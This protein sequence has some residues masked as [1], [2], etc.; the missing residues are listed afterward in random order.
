MV[1][2]A[3]KDTDI[4]LDILDYILIDQLIHLGTSGFGLAIEDERIN[5]FLTKLINELNS[6]KA[7][8]KE[9]NNA[10]ATLNNISRLVEIEEDF[11]YL[12]P[13]KLIGKVLPL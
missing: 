9:I 11:T 12:Y 7:K 4:N 10:N 8:L 5:I 2:F 13:F 1:N 6:Q 3:E